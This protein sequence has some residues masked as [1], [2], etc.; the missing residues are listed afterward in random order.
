M[1]TV[2]ITID[3]DTTIPGYGV[4]YAGEYTIECPADYDVDEIGA[5][6]MVFDCSI[7]VID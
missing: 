4:V 3:S 7:T 6:D 2:T 5:E 1:Q